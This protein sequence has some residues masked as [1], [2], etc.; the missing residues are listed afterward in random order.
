[1]N[2][3][4]LDAVDRRIFFTA[5][6]P[7]VI[8]GSCVSCLLA[9]GFV[10]LGAGLWHRWQHRLPTLP[11]NFTRESTRSLRI[12]VL[13]GSSAAGEPY[14]PWVSVGQIVAWQLAAVLPDLNVECE[15]L[16][17]PGDSLEM[18]HHKLAALER[19]P[20]VVIIYSGHNEFAAR[21]EEER[22]GWQDGSPSRN[23]ISTLARR[24]GLTS[25]FCGLTH[26]I[27]SK[28]R[29]DRPPSMALRHQLIDPPVCSDREKRDI[30][31]RF[32]PASRSHRVVLRPAW[33]LA[34]LDHPAGQ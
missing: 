10:E 32:S 15:I 20:D 22:E 9:V 2:G 27:I 33:R 1:M 25:A 34:H 4:E 16:A 8:E 31:G 17:Y 6:A 13:G 3:G 23:G 7:I 18:Q 24:I 26:E 11:T 30:E 14:W 29:L 5:Q 21:F 28:N 12:L 19:R